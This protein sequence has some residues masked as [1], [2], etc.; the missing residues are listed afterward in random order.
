MKRLVPPLGSQ[1]HLLFPKPGIHC[2]YSAP[3]SATCF[4]FWSSLSFACHPPVHADRRPTVAFR[5][6]PDT[7]SSVLLPRPTAHIFCP[8]THCQRP[9]AHRKFRVPDAPLYD[10]VHQRSMPFPHLVNSLLTILLRYNYHIIKLTLLKCTI[11]RFLVCSQRI[12]N[13][14]QNQF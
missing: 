10:A 8:F 2:A 12:T 4:S 11:Q 7:T 5:E 1:S 14:H 3:S 9:S 6:N 13:H